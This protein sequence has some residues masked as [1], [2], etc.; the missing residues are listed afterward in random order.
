M[1]TESD[2]IC[3][4]QGRISQLELRTDVQAKQIDVLYRKDTANID[5]IERLESDK[6]NLEEWIKT[7]DGQIATLKAALINEKAKRIVLDG[8]C[9]FRTPIKG[10][11]ISKCDKDIICNWETCKEKLNKMMEAKE[12]LAHDMPEIFGDDE[13]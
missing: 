1:S 2:Y 12:Q 13:I 3:R 6:A 4:L 10:A 5:V 8:Y 7:R 11:L 9:E